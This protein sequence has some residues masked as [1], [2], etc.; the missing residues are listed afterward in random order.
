[1]YKTKLINRIDNG[2]GYWEY[3]NIGIFY[4]DKQIGSYV[5]NYGS[6]APFCA[7]SQNGKDYAVYSKDYTTTRVMELPS[8]KDIGGEE[9]NEW[10]F[11]PVELYVPEKSNGKFGFVSGC[12][13]GFDSGGWYIK[14]LDL[15]DVMNM[16]RIDKYNGLQIPDVSLK[17]YVDENFYILSKED[18]T[19]DDI[20]QLP[21]YR[22]DDDD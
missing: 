21:C 17:V 20:K 4:D 2:K 3:L 16:K 6:G 12:V 10:G 22:D 5:Y 18:I 14:Y 1:M 19:D 15:S 8:C 9:P 13:W 11:C 7:F